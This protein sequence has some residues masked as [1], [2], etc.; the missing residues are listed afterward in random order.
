M[1][2]LITVMGPYDKLGF[3]YLGVSEPN[4]FWV[5]GGIV[6]PRYKAQKSKLPALLG[7]KFKSNLSG[8]ENMHCAGFHR[9]FTSGNAVFVKSFSQAALLVGA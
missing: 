8:V 2:I 7:E 4:F 5:R 3:N 1:P 9:V 6:I